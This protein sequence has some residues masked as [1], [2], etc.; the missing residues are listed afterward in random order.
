MSVDTLSHSR[1]GGNPV[2]LAKMVVRF[3]DSSLRGN[4]VPI[5][6]AK[7]ETHFS[8]HVPIDQIRGRNAMSAK[9]ICHIFY[10]IV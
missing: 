2:P 6:F 1:A 10:R 8:G 4:A 5:K 9:G 3:P 7:I